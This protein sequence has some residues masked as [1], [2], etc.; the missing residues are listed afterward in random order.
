MK[1]FIRAHSDNDQ[2]QLW[3][4]TVKGNK[5]KPLT[6]SRSSRIASGEICLNFAK[7]A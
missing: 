2:E 3:R 6:N 4:V 5:M 7:A 1:I